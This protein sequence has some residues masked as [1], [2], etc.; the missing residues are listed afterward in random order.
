MTQLQQ[1]L[2]LDVRY[3]L[4]QAP[5]AGAQDSKLALAVSSAGAIGSLPGAMLSPEKLR[6]ELEKIHSATDKPINF[7]FFCHQQPVPD[8]DREA[9]WR[10]LLSPYYSELGIVEA[11]IP[12]GPA[13]APFSAEIAQTL[14]PFRP[15]L[16]SFHFGLPEPEL[17]QRVK[18]WGSKILVSATT[19]AEARWL[20]Q[21]GVDA[22]IAQG[23]EAGGHR[24][25]F[26]NTDLAKQPTT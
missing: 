21:Q 1:V 22:I 24:G 25:M 12:T 9:A 3:P 16:V 11:D 14:E 2:K 26:L 17:L 18:S 5:M 23:I 8:P 10:E 6:M 20:Q 7:N 13:R 15:Q 19:V 4:I